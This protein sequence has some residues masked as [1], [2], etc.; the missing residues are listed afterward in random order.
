MKEGR[1][2]ICLT[3]W[4]DICGTQFQVEGETV[5]ESLDATQLLIEVKPVTEFIAEGSALEC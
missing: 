2:Y 1:Y 5:E 4:C 3:V